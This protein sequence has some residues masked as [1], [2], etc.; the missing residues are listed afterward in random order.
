MDNQEYDVAIAGGGNAALS[1]A[2]TAASNSSRVLLLEK[3][4][5]WDRGGNTKYIRDIRYAHEQDKYTTGPYSEDEF[6]DDLVKV[7]GNEISLDLAKL[8]ISR[9]REIPRWLEENGIKITGAI[10]GTLHLGRTNLF[11]LGG[12]KAMLNAFYRKAAEK[13][14]RILYESAVN[15]MRIQGEEIEEITVSSHGETREY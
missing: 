3:A 5:I 4:P 6:L 15:E 13:N 9:S 11:P 2:L 8:T 14:V 10:K 1:A 12:G 7:T